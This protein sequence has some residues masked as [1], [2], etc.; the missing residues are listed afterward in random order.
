[1]WQGDQLSVYVR[2][3]DAGWTT[4][5]IALA[6]SH[7][8]VGTIHFDEVEAVLTVDGL[9]PEDIDDIRHAIHDLIET[10]RQN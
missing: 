1:M 10:A 7:S 5:L 4:R 3:A 6:A 8:G 9:A 2:G